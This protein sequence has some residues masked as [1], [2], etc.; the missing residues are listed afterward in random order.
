MYSCKIVHDDAI[1]LLERTIKKPV[2]S[3]FDFIFKLAS[4]KCER[5][6]QPELILTTIQSELKRVKSISTEKI[7]KIILSARKQNINFDEL[8]F[9]SVKNRLGIYEKFYKRELSNNIA[10]NLHDF[11]KRLLLRVAR[12]IYKKPYILGKDSDI[13][14]RKKYLN[15]VNAIVITSLHELLLDYVPIRDVLSKLPVHPICR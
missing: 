4:N 8:V 13:Q 15:E 6:D 5:S 12:K 2:R 10:F 14:L 9:N 7:D 3:Y 11:I 1:N